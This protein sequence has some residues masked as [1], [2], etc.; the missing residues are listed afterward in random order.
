M[1][2]P[3]TVPVATTYPSGRPSA[4]VRLPSSAAD[5]TPRRASSNAPPPLCW[6]PRYTTVPAADASPCGADDVVATS[7]A[8]SLTSVS[9]AD[10]AAPSVLSSMTMVTF[11][12]KSS[13]APSPEMC[14]GAGYRAGPAYGADEARPATSHPAT[15]TVASRSASTATSPTR[16]RRAFSREEPMEP[17]APENHS[18]GLRRYWP[19]AVP[20][21]DGGTRVGG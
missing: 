8:T 18:R 20:A 11:P 12:E 2:R 16:P 4:A 13:A 14:C 6:V 7:R 15:S 10:R 1:G 21:H 17:T 19:T 3:D 9:R 5:R